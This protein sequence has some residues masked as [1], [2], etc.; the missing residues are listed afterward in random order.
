MIGIL[1]DFI[2]SLIYNNLALANEESEMRVKAIV[3]VSVLGFALNALGSAAALAS[4][5]P[6]VILAGQDDQADAK[7]SRRICK[8]ILPT[9]SRLPIRTCRTKEEWDR[10]EQQ[11]Q[12]DAEQQRRNHETV[13]PGAFTSNF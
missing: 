3:T 9:G 1:R 12:R 10:Q 2:V 4:G 5:D 7:K 13:K 11:F 6:T 8:M